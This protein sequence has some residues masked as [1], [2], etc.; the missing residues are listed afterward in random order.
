[1]TDPLSWREFTG[2]PKLRMRATTAKP[3]LGPPA[4]VNVLLPATDYGEAT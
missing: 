4:S 3:I 1:M 2:H